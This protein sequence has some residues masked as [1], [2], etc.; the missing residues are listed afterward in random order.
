M[1]L[2]Y[3]RPCSN[4]TSSGEINVRMLFL[5]LPTLPGSDRRFPARTGL[6]G[7]TSSGAASLLDLQRR[8]WVSCDEFGACRQYQAFAGVLLGALSGAARPAEHGGTRRR[9]QRF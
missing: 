8:Y 4:L 1:M 7:A 6:T 2:S 3:L 9:A 5:F